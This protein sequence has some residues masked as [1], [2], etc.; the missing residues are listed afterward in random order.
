METLHHL[1]I[2]WN[3]LGFENEILWRIS[4]YGKLW[5]D[6]QFSTSGD[7]ALIGARNFIKNCLANP[8]PWD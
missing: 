2:L 5:S 6:D 8:P 7:K 3:E 1:E 4:G